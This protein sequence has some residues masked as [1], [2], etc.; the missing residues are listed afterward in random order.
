VPRLFEIVLAIAFAGSSCNL[1]HAAE[2]RR[3]FT[4]IGDRTCRYW[5]ESKLGESGSNSILATANRTWFVGFI[6][7]LNAGLTAP[8]ALDAIDAE[9]AEEWVDQ[10][11]LRH[12]DQPLSDAGETLIVELIKMKLPRK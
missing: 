8:D 12:A 9:S 3:A 1:M 7:G 5:T 11:C 10:Y 6:S 4:T 2:K